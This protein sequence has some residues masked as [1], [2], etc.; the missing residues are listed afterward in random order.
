MKENME[1]EAVL[2]LIGEYLKEHKYT[3]TLNALERE[4]WALELIVMM[5]C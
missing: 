2:I 1:D 3:G 4:R 5:S